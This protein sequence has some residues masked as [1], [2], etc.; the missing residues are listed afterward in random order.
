MRSIH[1]IYILD[2]LNIQGQNSFWRVLKLKKNSYCFIASL[3]IWNSQNLPAFYFFSILG[4]VY[5]LL[6]FLL[7]LLYWFAVLLNL[8]LLCYYCCW[9]L[10]LL[11]LYCCFQVHI[12]TISAWSKKWNINQALFLLNSS[13]LDLWLNIIFLSSYKDVVEWLMNNEVAYVYFL[14]LIMLV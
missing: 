8:L 1:P 10:L 2:T 9:L 13:C 11:F 3:K 6:G 7:F 4:V 5:S 12:C 14:H